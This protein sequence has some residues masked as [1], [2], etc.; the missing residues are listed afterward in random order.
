MHEVLADALPVTAA[1]LPCDG[2]CRY[3]LPAMLGC[4]Q[5]EAHVASVSYVGHS[6]GTTT[7]LAALSSDPG[8][9]AKINLAILFAPVTFTGHI[10][11]RPLVALARMQTAEV[12]LAP[13]RAVLALPRDAL[14]PP[15][16]VHDP[17]R[18]VHDPPR[19]ALA[20]PRVALAPPR[21][22]HVPPRVVHDPPRDALALPT[23]CA[24]SLVSSEV[25][26]VA[27]FPVYSLYFIP[28]F[29]PSF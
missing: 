28:L 6:Q 17:P 18:V 19:V 16:V 24:F 7:L 4:V 23:R 8:M 25:P 12:A 27:L 26:H 2:G 21:V 13:P 1:R 11:S 15:R 10:R 3:D 22:V 20:L 14:A 29:S 5:L 9:A